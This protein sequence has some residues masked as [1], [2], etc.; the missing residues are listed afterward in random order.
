MSLPDKDLLIS[1]VVDTRA[2]PA[3]WAM[4]EKLAANDGTVWR[5][6][7]QA[8]RDSA[9]MSAAVER[10]A[11]R[12]ETVPL[13]EADTFRFEAQSPAW[14]GR[15]RGWLG[16]AAAAVLLVAFVGTH[17]GSNQHSAGGSTASLLPTFSSAID[18]QPSV[19]LDRYLEKGH[20]AGL[21]VGELPERVIVRTVD[22]GEGKGSEVYYLRQIMEKRT[23]PS[24]YRLEQAMDES[25]RSLPRRVPARI[26][27]SELSPM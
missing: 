13:P 21:V 9:L 19:H 23:L 25:G 10:A 22:L 8:Q 24:L 2:T 14:L 26:I 17:A 4:L 6:L 5:E 3:D 11:A 27:T 16:W 12:A 1:R 15:A 7:A 20:E 18:T